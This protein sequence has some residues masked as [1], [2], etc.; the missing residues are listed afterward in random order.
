MNRCVSSISLSELSKL[1]ACAI[2]LDNPPAGIRIKIFARLHDMISAE[3]VK[4][5]TKSL[6]HCSI[7]QQI[8]M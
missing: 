3:P 4:H 5:K 2:E 1:V 7:R 6:A 8:L